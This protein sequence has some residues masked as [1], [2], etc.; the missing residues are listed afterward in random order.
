MAAAKPMATAMP[1]AIGILGLSVRPSCCGNKK[2]GL[3]GECRAVQVRA[4]GRRT[5]C[6]AGIAP[7]E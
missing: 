5:A 1:W 7:R 6:G 4:G 2:A 3:G